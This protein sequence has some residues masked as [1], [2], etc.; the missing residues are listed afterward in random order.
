MRRTILHA[1]GQLTKG[2]AEKQLYLLTTGLRER[3]WDIQVLSLSKGGWWKEKL[4]AAAVPV[5]DI[6]ARGSMEWRRLQFARSVIRRLSPQLLHCWLFQANTYARVGALGQRPPVVI[7]SERMLDNEKSRLNLLIDRALMLTT[8]RMIS[9]SQAAVDYMA[10]NF[11]YRPEQMEVLYNGIESPDRATDTAPLLER[12]PLLRQWR[13]EPATVVIGTVGRLMRQKMPEHFIETI[14]RLQA[15]PVPVRGLLV[16][17]GALEQPLRQLVVKLNLTGKICFTGE[18]PAAGPALQ[19]MDI[20]LQTSRKE[21]LSNAI[22]EAMQ[23]GLP[24]VVS[25]VGGNR[26]LVAAGAA[27]SVI[28]F[29][30]IAGYCRK[31]RPLLTDRDTC[32]RLGENGRSFIADSFSIPRM[33]DQIEQLYIQLLRSKG[34]YS[35]E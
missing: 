14:G 30:D 2:G 13:D 18:L 5:H 9:N 3:G 22:M 21:G 8:D 25:E 16:G 29:G 24:C 23:Q 31:L 20:Y 33:I 34:V 15:E 10:H 1:I 35:D 17:G 7:A 12:F 4:E 26:E 28:P 27:G 32:H 11:G 19:L 6:E